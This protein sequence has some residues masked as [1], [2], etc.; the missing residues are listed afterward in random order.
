MIVTPE[1]GIRLE[2]K[3]KEEFLGKFGE[4][5][6]KYGIWLGVGYFD[7]Q[8]R[9]NRLAFIGPSGEIVAQ[10]EKTHLISGLEKYNPGDGTLVH[11]TSMVSRLEE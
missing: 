6:K 5:S 3:E 1:V 4:L 9:K 8:D 7:K 2:D 10:Y 11:V